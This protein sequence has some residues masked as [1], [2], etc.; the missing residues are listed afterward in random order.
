MKT[1]SP[2]KYCPVCLKECREFEPNEGGTV[3]C[4]TDRY[5]ANCYWKSHKKDFKEAN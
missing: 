1:R 5:H 2:K 3:T 4:G